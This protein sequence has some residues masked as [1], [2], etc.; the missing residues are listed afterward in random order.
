MTESCKIEE[1]AELAAR[2]SALVE[3]KGKKK[4]KEE[5]EY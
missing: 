2:M 4:K 1:D 5:E 3:S